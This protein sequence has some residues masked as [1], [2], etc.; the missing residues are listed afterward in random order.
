MST[1]IDKINSSEY[2][3]STYTKLGLKK[4]TCDIAYFTEEPLDDLYYVICSILN[5]TEK[6]YYDKLS[7]GNILGFSMSN[8]KED[9]ENKVY[10]DEAEVKIFEDLLSLVEQEHLIRIDKSLIYLTKLGSISL[11]ENKHY[12]FYTGFQNIFEHLTIKSRK[13]IEMLMFPFY[14]DMGISSFI[15]NSHKIWPK[16]EDIEQIIYYEDSQIKQRIKLQSKESLNIYFAELKEYYDLETITVP[17]KLYKSSIDYIPVIFKNDI[18]AERATELLNEEINNIKKENVILECLF[19]KLWDEKSSIFNYDS[20]KPYFDLINYEELTK[21]SRVV[22]TDSKLFKVIVRN[23]S[24]ICWKNISRNCDINMLRENI[25]DYSN[26]LDWTI[27]TERIDD[28]FLIKNFLRYPWDLDIL[29]GDYNR[30]DAVIEQLILLQKET[31]EDWNWNELE[32]RLSQKFILAHLD[33]VKVNLASYTNDS[34]DIRKAILRNTNKR[35]DWNKIESEFSLDFI[36]DNISILG[37]HF[38]LIKLFDRVFTSPT[39]CA[40]FVSSNSFLDIIKHASVEGGALSSAIFNDKEYLWSCDIIDLLC[41]NN[42]LCWQSTQYMKGFECNPYLVW[43][44]DFFDKYSVN[45]KTEEGR[46]YV[47]SHISDIDILIK[48]INF[49]WDWDSISS[50]QCLL[51]DLRLFSYYG[52]KLNWKIVLTNIKNT[53]FLQ[54]LNDIKL[55]IGED[56]EAWTLF[57]S[58]ATIDYVIDKYKKFNFPWD[59]TVLTKRMFSKLKLENLGNKLFVEHWD[60]TYLSDHLNIEFIKENIE[61][62]NNYWNW[63][64]LLP[65]ILNS[66]ERFDLI[67]LEQLAIILNKISD[68]ERCR[69][70]WTALTKQYSFKDLKKIIKETKEN[71]VYR[72]DIQYLCLHEEFNVFK[73]LEDCR[74]IIDWSILSNSKFVD[75]SFKYNKKLGI[76]EDG[77]Y[78]EIR[79]ILSDE[80]N[81]WDY[82]LLSHFESLRDKKWFISQYRNKIDWNYISQT[83]KIFCVTDKQKLNEIIDTY[84]KYIDFKELS[85]RNDVDIEQIMKINP[86]GSYNY[87]KLIENGRIKVTMQHIKD[88]PNYPWDW[89]LVTSSPYFYPTDKFLLSHIDSEINWELLSLQGN[90]KAWSNEELIIAVAKKESIKKQ[91]NWKAISSLKEFPITKKV[92]SVIPI[93]AINWTYISSRKSIVPYIDEFVDYIDWKVI[94]NSQHINSLEIGFLDKYK[95]YIDWN[96]ICKKS[97]FKF[98]NEILYLFEDYIDWNLASNSKDIK[99]TTELIEK[100]KDKWNWSVLAKNKAFFNKVDISNM[101]YIK[102]INIIDFISKFPLKPKAY[103]FTNMDNAVKIIRAM[104]LQSRN[105]ANG[106]FSNSAGS[107]VNITSKAHKFARFYFAPKSPTQFYNECLGKDI[108]D[109]KYYGKALNLGL[110]KCPLPVF[111]IFDV[112]ELLTIIPELCYYS[113][114]NMQKDSSKCFKVVEDPHRIKARE[115]YINS[116]ETFDERQQEF[117]VEGEL[118]FSKLKNVQICCYDD[119]QVSMLKKELKGTKWENIVTCGNGL[120]ERN[121]KELYFNENDESIV[122]GTNYKCPY[123]LKI[124]YNGNQIPNILNKQNVIRQRGNNIYVSSRVEISKYTPFEVYFEVNSP[125]NGS[126]LIYKN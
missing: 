58:V 102:Q 55:M 59:W 43:N 19:Q 66:S 57:S 100:Y 97:D 95:E 91:I 76:K 90:Q 111:F 54:Q 107:N 122:I 80:R 34:E 96:I 117:L 98:N 6:K 50:N 99:F 73:D 25:K 47:S 71:H 82:A 32:N 13:S 104:K 20:L 105:Y 44:K 74:E 77:W 26:Y 103:H 48:Y 92:L 118:D 78:N 12:Q 89:Y 42:L 106:N 116:F 21:D 85:I 84:K 88:M 108:D 115:I 28:T 65:R 60:W 61:K 113:N 121:N 23:A 125:R 109:R 52:N 68:K 101:P 86:N 31:E 94:S 120:Y 18:I 69:V 123:E 119:F 7:L 4:Y 2:I 36:Y 38:G 53:S 3:Y 126:W 62:Y 83:S 63:E 10:Y 81:N 49:K 30:N 56:K 124:T 9:G 27:L 51:S 33:I 8:L 75:E 24:A 37:I 110:P 87:N 67:T 72:W 41:S 22:W 46:K 40:K 29:S 14:D 70:G 39:W 17:I 45:I 16:D 93:D 64:V 11:K 1:I 79:K 15:N 5:S 35:W 114:G 112:E